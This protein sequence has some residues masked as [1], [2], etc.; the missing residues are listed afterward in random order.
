M[1]MDVDRAIKSLQ[2]VAR[3]VRE[4][5]L[6]LESDD[7]R[8]EDYLAALIGS[9][10]DAAKGLLAAGSASGAENC[11]AGAVSCGA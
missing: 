8:I 6:R 4:G 5:L 10:L 3:D 1:V 9:G 2:G 11:L 7:Q